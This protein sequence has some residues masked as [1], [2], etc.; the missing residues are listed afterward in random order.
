[1]HR[2]EFHARILR[3]AAPRGNSSA[4]GTGPR[5]PA[6]G[7]GAASSRPTGGWWPEHINIKSDLWQKKIHIY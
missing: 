5:G 3:A 1:M 6:A 2:S 4:A 7:S